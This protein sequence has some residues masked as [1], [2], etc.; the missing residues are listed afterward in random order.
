MQGSST[1]QT[2]YSLF[3][4]FPA[5]PLRDSKARLPQAA[6]LAAMQAERVRGQQA[7]AA[8]D[9]VFAPAP[10]PLQHRFTK[11]AMN[12]RGVLPG[13]SGL[14]VLPGLSGSRVLP[15]LNGSRVL[16]AAGGLLLSCRR[17]QQTLLMLFGST[18]SSIVFYTT[19]GTT[20]LE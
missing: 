10:P 4:C 15:G 17:G 16:A 18:V 3:A 19:F 14:R 8:P 2:L 20:K 6:S 1:Q 5:L 7:I 13:L 11:A 9:P 12:L